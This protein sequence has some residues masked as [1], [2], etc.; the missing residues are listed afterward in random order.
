LSVAEKVADGW[1]GFLGRI[2]HPDA[3]GVTSGANGDFSGLEG[4]KHCLV[5]TF[6]RSGE[7]VPTPVWVGFAD[8]RLYF[9][10]E[11]RAG[12]I[13]RIRTNPRVVVAPCDNR[14][15]PLGEPVEG[16]ARVVPAAGEERAEAAIQSN[17]GLGRRIY[18]GVAMNL[19]PEGAY[20]EVAPGTAPAQ[21]QEA[22]A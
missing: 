18:E 8:G 2:R 7:A 1:N 14:G 6:R 5:V 22:G 15:K 17:F 12:K 19:G 21:G 3:L 9:R 20:V 13:K 11:K 4:R 16:R 10:S